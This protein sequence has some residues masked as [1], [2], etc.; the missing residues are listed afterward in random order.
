[1]EVMETEFE[2]RR[3]FMQTEMSRTKDDLE[4]MK[5]KFRRLDGPSVCFSVFS[6]RSLPSSS[7]LCVLGVYS[8]LALCRISLHEHD[9]FFI[10]L[11][12]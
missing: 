3:H 2:S 5:D 10:N 1:M 8:E 9:R 7:C 4:K 12:E 6:S 11:T